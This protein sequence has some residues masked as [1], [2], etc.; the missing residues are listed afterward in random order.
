MRYRR[1]LS[2]LLI[3][4]IITE[5]GCIYVCYLTNGAHSKIQN[6]IQPAC[7]ERFCLLISWAKSLEW[8]CS[9]QRAQACKVVKRC[10]CAAH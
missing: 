9:S 4:L 10:D 7:I 8:R 1:T 6:R 5:S 2:A 3:A